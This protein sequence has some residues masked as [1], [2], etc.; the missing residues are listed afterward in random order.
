MTHGPFQPLPFCDSVIS[1]VKTQLRKFIHKEF[2]NRSPLFF[3]RKACKSFQK[4]IFP[5]VYFAREVKICSNYLAL[6]PQ[7]LMSSQASLRAWERQFEIR[8][9]GLS[10]PMAT[11][12]YLLLGQTVDLF[13]CFSVQRKRLENC[14]YWECNFS[15]CNPSN[16]YRSFWV[17]S[18]MWCSM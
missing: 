2:V 9:G 18:L 13:S 7:T 4:D 15:K 6:F 3:S 14:K 10:A 5:A 8:A 1:N 12:V 17:L 11:F 16:C